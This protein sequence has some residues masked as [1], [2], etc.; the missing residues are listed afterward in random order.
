MKIF[1]FFDFL[2]SL[3]NWWKTPTHDHRTLKMWAFTHLGEKYAKIYQFKIILHFAYLG[4]CLSV[5][6]IISSKGQ[7]RTWC[8]FLLFVLSLYVYAKRAIYFYF[9]SSTCSSRM[10]RLNR[11]MRNRTNR[12]NRTK[13]NNICTG[14]VWS[15]LFSFTIFALNI[16]IL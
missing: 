15:G 14:A 1:N 3:L 6:T 8:M 12:T 11:K 5:F 2:E 10:I 7:P 4:G 16:R 9:G 13:Q